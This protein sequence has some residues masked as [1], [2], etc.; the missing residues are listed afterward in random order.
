VALTTKGKEKGKGLYLEKAPYRLWQ[1]SFVEEN[2]LSK[3][4]HGE[5]EKQFP[6]REE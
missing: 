6:V 4:P 5:K 2:L 1:N 3:R